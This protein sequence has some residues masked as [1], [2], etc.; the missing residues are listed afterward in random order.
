MQFVEQNPPGT[1]VDPKKLERLLG[2]DGTNGH[3]RLD[4][5][6]TYLVANGVCGPDTPT[7]FEIGVGSIDDGIDHVCLTQAKANTAQLKAKISEIPRQEIRQEIKQE[8]KQ[9]LMVAN[10]SIRQTVPFHRR[11]RVLEARWQKLCALYLPRV[12]TES[13]WRCHHPK[14]HRQ[15]PVGWKLHISATILN[16]PAVLKRIGPF[17][18]ARGVPFK[19]PRSLIEVGEAQLRP[20]LQLHSDWQNHYCL[21]ANRRRSGLSRAAAARN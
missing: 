2:T 6:R 8:I 12:P 19:A 21:S 16:A 10:D 7:T 11:A 14:G 17:L 9:E 15:R 3:P 4:M 20:E 1:A 18:T 13:I 5:S